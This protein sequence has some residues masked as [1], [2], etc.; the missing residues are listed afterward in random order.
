[1]GVL[2]VALAARAALRPV[3]PVRLVAAVVLLAPV[4]AAGVV[5]LMSGAVPSRLRTASLSPIVAVVR[6]LVGARV[7]PAVVRVPAG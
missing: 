5:P 2:R 7:A 3:A 4:A 1:M 6:A